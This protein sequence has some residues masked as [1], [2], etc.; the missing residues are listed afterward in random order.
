M[1]LSNL[2]SLCL[3]G[4]MCDMMG[5]MHTLEKIRNDFKAD[6]YKIANEFGVSS[7]RVFGSVVR[8]EQGELSDIDFLIK[9]PEGAT[10]F[11]LV[12]FQRKL[13]ELFKCNVDV[14]TESGLS[15]HLKQIV[16]SE[17]V[18]L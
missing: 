13:E 3:M 15:R 11:T 8:G 17:S 12:R 6:V 5:G 16:E 14:V 18:P 1:G 4:Q 7:I 2:I 9:A 10:F